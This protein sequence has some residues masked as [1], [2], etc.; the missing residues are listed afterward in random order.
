[1]AEEQLHGRGG[2]RP[3]KN[4]YYGGRGIHANGAGTPSGDRTRPLRAFADEPG[5][6]RD[7]AAAVERLIYDICEPF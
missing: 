7:G 3:I 4:L 1:M 2:G 6:K 5:A